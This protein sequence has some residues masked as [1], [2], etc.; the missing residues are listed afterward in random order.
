[1][2]VEIRLP[3]L[4]GGTETEQLR[5]VQNYLF[6]L[7]QQLQFA[8]D[9]VSREQALPRVSSAA[10]PA[11]AA[12][13]TPDFGAIKALI[14]KSAELTE[15]FRQEVEKTLTG[16]YVAQS[17]FGTFQQETEQRLTANDQELRQQFT[18]V[19]RLETDLAGLEST[20]REVNATLR[21][22]LLGEEDGQSIYGVEI[23]QETRED[24][25]LRFRK[26]TRL[27]AQR[28]SFYD[29][30]DIEVA[31]ISDRRLMVTEARVQQLET[32]S[33]T[34][35]RLQLGAYLWELGNDGHLSIR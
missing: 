34:A 5:R 24:G 19:Q 21:T 25:V 7:A 17:R 33:L 4:S 31:C 26:Y 6:Y 3:E 8:F 15:H 11:K 28:L 16:R 23:G 27:T 14:L 9:T 18:N 29:S 30:N 32:Q 20:V 35:G 22:G 13:E 12:R 1:M 10:A 2:P